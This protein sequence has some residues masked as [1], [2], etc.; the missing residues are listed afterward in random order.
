MSTR[1]KKQARSPTKG[2]VIEKTFKGKVH[3]VTVT[4]TGFRY[5]RKEYASLTAVA[6]EIT[7]YRSISGPA[8]FG[9]TKASKD[10]R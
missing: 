3:K 7:G 5:G 2:D 6:R 4:E 10:R 1:K 8:F 9:L